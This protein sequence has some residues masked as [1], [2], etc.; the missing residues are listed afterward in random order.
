MSISPDKKI[1]IEDIIKNNKTFIY[2]NTNPKKLGK[3]T[4]DRYNIYKKATN[5]KEFLKLGGIRNDFYIDLKIN[6]LY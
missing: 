2:Q 3:S 6:I 5:Y 4:H 1:I